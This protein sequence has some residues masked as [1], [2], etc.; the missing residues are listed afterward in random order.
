MQSDHIEAVWGAIEIGKV[1]NAEARRTFY[2]L[3]KGLLPARKVGGVWQSTRGEL[4]DFLLGI[5][6]A[7]KHAPRKVA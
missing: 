6:P 4:R 3:E 1:I 2:L 7:D 5:P